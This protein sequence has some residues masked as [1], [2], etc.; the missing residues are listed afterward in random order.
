[1]TP[2]QM[3]RQVGVIVLVILVIITLVI[4]ALPIGGVVSY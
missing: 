3:L 2:G 1:M 4:S